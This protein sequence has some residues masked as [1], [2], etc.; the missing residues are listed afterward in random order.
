MQI[1]KKTLPSI[2]FVTS[3]IS[4]VAY[5]NLQGVNHC[6]LIIGTDGDVEFQY[7]DDVRKFVSDYFSNRALVNP[8]FFKTELDKNKR[9]VFGF[10]RSRGIR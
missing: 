9:L 6:S 2:N 1:N 5:F 4:L 7:S 10:L 8:L 3:D